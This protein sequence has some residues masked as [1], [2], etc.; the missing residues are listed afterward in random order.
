MIGGKGLHKGDSTV[1]LAEPENGEQ[2]FQ[3]RI[4]ERRSAHGEAQLLFTLL[5]QMKPVENNTPGGKPFLKLLQN[6]GTQG[7]RAIDKE[8]KMPGLEQVMGQEKGH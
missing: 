3:S 6:I 4:A 1:H 8:L 7:A 2:F 5:L